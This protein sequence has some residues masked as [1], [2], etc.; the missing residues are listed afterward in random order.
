MAKK[1]PKATPPSRKS[2]ARSKKTALT[3]SE[4]LELAAPVAEQVQIRGVLLAEVRSKRQPDADGSRKD[5]QVKI[6][7]VRVDLAPQRDVNA[8]VVQPTFRLRAEWLDQRDE[9]AP[10][11][12]EGTFVAFYSLES[13]ENFTDENL[14]AFAQ[15]NGVFNVW[16]YWRELAQSMVSRM[17]LPPFTVPVF[18]C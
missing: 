7:V 12:I 3:D 16:P 8:F 14:Q 1:T 13:I 9:A 4:L 5:I 2:P 17:G 15:V 10:F 18:R 6:E 11:E